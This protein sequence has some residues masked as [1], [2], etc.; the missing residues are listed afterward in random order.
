[1]RGVPCC[2]KADSTGKLCRCRQRIWTLPRRKRAQRARS[3]SPLACR[4][5][6]WDCRATIRSPIIGGQSR[7]LATDRSAACLACAEEFSG[8]GATRLR[9]FRLDYNVD[10]LEALATERAIE[11]DRIGKA[12]FLTLTNSARRW[13]T[14]RRRRMAFSRNGAAGSNAATRRTSRA[15]RQGRRRV[16]SGRAAG[17]AKGTSRARRYRDEL[18]SEAPSMLS[19][20]TS[21]VFKTGAMTLISWKRSP[22]FTADMPFATTLERPKRI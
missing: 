14:A 15:R 11:W 17:A 12:S 7:L 21:V 2:W 22:V 20:Q 9:A 16:D 5:C 10:R 4:R 6:C 8:L 13:A 1:M 18:R 19:I 3:R